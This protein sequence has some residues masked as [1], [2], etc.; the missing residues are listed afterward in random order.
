MDINIDSGNLFYI[1]TALIVFRGIAVARQGKQRKVE[2][3]MARARNVGG[4]L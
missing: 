1:V 4:A 3:A 2:N